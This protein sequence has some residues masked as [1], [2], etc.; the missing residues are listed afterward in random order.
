M[1]LVRDRLDWIGPQ[2]AAE[3]L[4]ERLASSVEFHF[5]QL[6]LNRLLKRASRLGGP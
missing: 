1:R 3:A 5:Q 2:R 4:S 6:R